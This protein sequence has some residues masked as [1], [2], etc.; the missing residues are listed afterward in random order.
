MPDTDL[1]VLVKAKEL[2]KHT[3]ILTS[4]SNR[5]PKRS[6]TLL[7]FHGKII[8]PTAVVIGFLSAWIKI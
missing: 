2:S 8:Y 5:Y 1:K 7:M 4:N 6:L 3:F